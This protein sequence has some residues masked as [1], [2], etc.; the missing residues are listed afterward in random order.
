M[1]GQFTINDYLATKITAREVKDLTAY[2]NAQGKAQYTQI[3]ELLTKKCN[4]YEITEDEEKID[5]L[6]NAISCYVLNMSL[7]YMEYLRNECS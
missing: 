7:G 6:T 2:I 3:W 1:D 5:R 4:E